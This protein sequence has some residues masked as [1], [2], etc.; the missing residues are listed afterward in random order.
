MSDLP[1]IGSSDVASILGLSKWSSPM[2]TWAQLTGVVPRYDNDG[3]AAIRRGVRME[4]ALRN[5][6]AEDIGKAVHPGPAFGVDPVWAAAAPYEWAHARPDGWYEDGPGLTLVECK[7]VRS[8]TDDE[9]G[10]DGSDDVPAYYLAQIVWQMGVARLG[11]RNVIA[12]DLVAFSPMSE[13]TR[14]F[15]VPY[16]DR[17]FRA[18]LSTVEAWRQ[19]HVLGGEPPPVDAHDATEKILAKVYPG[20]IEKKEIEPSDAFLFAVFFF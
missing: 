16:D 3:N 14:T 10:V 18:L 20:G 13:E 1:T 12:C 4:A 19:R 8:F 17:R 6:R 9:W 7:T 2:R 15:V 11:G 5:W